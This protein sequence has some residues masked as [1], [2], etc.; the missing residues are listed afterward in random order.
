MRI[1]VTGANGQLGSELKFLSAQNPQFE[2][3][4]C[5]SKE[6]DITSEDSV[7]K[8]VEGFRP[9][10]IVNCA[11]YTAVDKAEE[12][13]E[14]AKAVNV[15]G[16]ENLVRSCAVHSCKLIHISTDYVFDGSGTTPYQAD[17]ATHPL[18]VYG[19]TKL[20]GEHVVLG[21][22]IP[23][24]VIRTSWVFS[25]FGNNFLKTMVRLG[26]ERSELNVV[27]DQSGRPTYARD[28]AKAILDITDNSFESIVK[29]EI[30]HFC[31][32]GITTWFDFASRIMTEAQLNCKIHP[33]TSAEF[34]TRAERPKYSVLD[35]SSIENRFGI[36]IRN[37][38]DALKEAL[39]EIVSL[40]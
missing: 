23:A 30:L 13:P 5:N 33:I 10:L 20:E 28:L 12:E 19:R 27:S 24:L 36:Q 2:F 35:T 40:N 29:P 25:S 14:K 22:K 31:N 32:K 16:V 3:R 21:S 8:N 34:P 11:A 38:E 18:G 39:I 7:K 9:N 17:T 4:F 1:L 15:L 26:S 6:L 37:W